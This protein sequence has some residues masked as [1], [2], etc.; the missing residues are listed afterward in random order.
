ML[1][2][3]IRLPAKFAS[4]VRKWKETTICSDPECRYSHALAR[5]FSHGSGSIQIKGKRYC[6][7]NCFDRT[8]LR[9]LQQLPAQ[10]EMMPA[11]AHRVPLGLLMLSRGELNAGQL[12]EALHA[13]RL[14]GKGYIGEWLLTLGFAHE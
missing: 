12:Q 11:R 10:R 1:I 2:R 8:L 9:K 14:S 6:F 4:T 13:Q 7:P 5:R 3:M